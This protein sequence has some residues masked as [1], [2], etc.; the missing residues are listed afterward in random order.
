L[1]G[2]RR[3]AAPTIHN[4]RH[5]DFIL[6]SDDCHARGCAIFAEVVDVGS[7]DR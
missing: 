4:Q 3:A 7:G 5:F 1:G 2:L 6:E